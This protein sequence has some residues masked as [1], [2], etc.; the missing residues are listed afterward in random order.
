MPLY[1]FRCRTCGTEKEFLR[2]IKDFKEPLCSF[3]CY[4]PEVQ[5]KNERMERVFSITGKP[6][7]KGNGFYETDYKEKPK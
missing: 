2:K 1:T 7:F 3:C 4:N 6:Q 5:G